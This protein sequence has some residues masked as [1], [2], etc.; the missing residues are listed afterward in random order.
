VTPAAVAQVTSGREWHLVSRP[1]SVPAV[2]DFELVEAAVRAAGEGELV[3]RNSWMSVDP[4]ARLRMQQDAPEYMPR[5]D[6]GRPIEGWAVGEVI[7]SRAQGFAVGDRVLHPHGWREYA[8]MSAAGGSRPAPELVAVDEDTPERAYLG[9][10]S[11]VGLTSYVGLLHVA[12]LR[13]DDIVFVSAAAGAVGSL[14]VQIAKLRGHVVVASAGSSEKVAHVRK[15]LGADSAF[16]YRDGPARELLEACAPDGIDLYFDNVAGEQLEAALDTLRPGG[17]V[18][19]CGAISAY[20]DE[21]RPAGP[22]N[23]FNAVTKGLTL[24]GFLSR[25]YGARMDE[26]REQMRV[27]LADGSIVYDEQIYDGIEQAPAALIDMF[28]GRNVGKVLVRVG[29][30]GVG[31]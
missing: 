2:S 16:C 21:G 18:A 22:A 25:M 8:V 17:R 30:R 23:L 20:N 6:L 27:W 5:F 12:E 28:A 10:L 7:E 4:S 19:L 3:V 24:R 13:P 29:A 31:G 1:R 9:A 14:V 26:F 15:A 11:W